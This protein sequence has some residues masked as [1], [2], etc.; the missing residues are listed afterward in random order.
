M[1]D[2]RSDVSLVMCLV[3]GFNAFTTL[4]FLDPFRVAN[5]LGGVDRYR[6]VFASE[7]GG[8]VASSIGVDIETIAVASIADQPAFA[9]LSAGW[10]PPDLELSGTTAAF[11]RWDRLGSIVGGLSS[12]A[13]L[14]AGMGLLEGYRS[15]VHYE[16]GPAFREAF[17]DLDVL[18]DTYV[19]DGKRIS[20]CGGTGSIDLALACI[21]R[22]GD[23][24]L[25]GAIGTY[26][27]HPNRRPNDT[28]QVPLDLDKLRQ[29]ARRPIAAL[30]EML[31]DPAEHGT[32][33]AGICGA[34]GIAPARLRRM[35]KAETGLSPSQLRDKMRFDKARTLV[36]QTQLP[37]TEIAIISGY[38]DLSV[39][40]RAYRTHVGVSPKADR[41]LWQRRAG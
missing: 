8:P 32:S 1:S 11:R 20:S 29:S 35:L 34:I 7:T 10:I 4:A 21:D 2:D 5:Y 25:V 3:P 41:R 13:Y 30:I 9:M 37:I 19:L 33:I 38:S 40:S 27:F 14:L 6:W 28:Q 36:L 23:G 22:M 17:P 15:T 18:G 26:I 24:G 39:F 16:T 31:E 12:A